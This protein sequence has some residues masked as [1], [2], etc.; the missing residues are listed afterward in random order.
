[1]RLLTDTV[2][3]MHFQPTDSRGNRTPPMTN[4]LGRIAPRN[5]KR[6]LLCAHWDTRPRADHDPDPRRRNEP[7][8]GANDGASGVAVLLEVATVLKQLRP[9]VGV[10]IVLFDGEDYGEEGRI[11]DYFLGSTEFSRRW[12]GPRHEMAILVD[13]VGDR[14]L[15]FPIEGFSWRSAPTVVN[16]VWDTGARLGERAFVRDYGPQIYDD[17]LPLIDAGWPAIDIIDFSYPW[18]HTHADTPDKCSP[19]SLRSVARVLIAVIMGN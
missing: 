5:P 16:R 8:L 14:N 2:E 12:R 3:V 9:G 13:M 1:M 7:I 19:E 10:D 6:Y 15:R 4:I 18:W 11:E 17:H